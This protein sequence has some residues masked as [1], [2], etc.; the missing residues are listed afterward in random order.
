MKP[1]I[2]LTE[3]LVPNDIMDALHQ[4]FTVLRHWLG[5]ADAAV[6]A[7][8]TTGGKGAS[9][10][11]MDQLPALKLIS[12][13]GVGVD[14]VDLEAA[15][16]RAIQVTNTPDVL[17]EDVADLAVALWLACAR[18][19]VRG[20]R[21]IRRGGW[22]QG[23]LASTTSTRGRRVGFYGFGRIGRAIARRLEV[24][25]AK[26]SYHKPTPLAGGAGHLYGYRDSLLE[27]ATHSDVLMV[28]TALTP[29][30]R[31]S[32]TD[33]VLR[34]LGPK[35]ILVNIARGAVIDEAAL[36]TCL[37][38]GGLGAAALDVFAHEP[39]VPEAL[40][41]L[42]NVVLTPHIGSNTIETRRAMGRLVIDNLSAHFQGRPLLTPVI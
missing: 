18:D 20:D 13:Y 29:A 6:E 9:R 41:T 25:D 10:A 19:V 37:Q 21:L 35:G 1:A 32:V 11:L 24:F 8:A 42:D 17:T 27:L 33:A 5:E 36:V 16:A 3:P 38:D 7:M 39:Q 28:C 34:A 2:L 12:V 31:L 40:W 14:A 22:L 26:I 30:T 4:R 15:K 23:G